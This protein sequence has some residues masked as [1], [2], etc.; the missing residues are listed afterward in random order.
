MTVV[1]IVYICWLGSSFLETLIKACTCHR[2]SL[3]LSLTFSHRFR[4]KQPPTSFASSLQQH[5]RVLC[6]PEQQGGMQDKPKI[7]M[8][9]SSCEGPSREHA[10]QVATQVDDQPV[11]TNKKSIV[12]LSQ[13]VRL[14][15]S[16]LQQV[17]TA[18]KQDSSMVWAAQRGC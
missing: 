3:K 10:I 15:K 5:Q 9:E 16:V 4:A 6:Q 17:L 8:E 18:S 11:E 14:G 13:C 12:C 2:I 1:G 7:I